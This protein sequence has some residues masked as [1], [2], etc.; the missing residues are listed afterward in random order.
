MNRCYFVNLFCKKISKFSRCRLF[1]DHVA[2]GNINRAESHAHGRP[3]D[4]KRNIFDHKGYSNSRVVIPRSSIADH[5]LDMFNRQC[6][7]TS[8]Q[9]LS[10]HSL[11]AGRQ[12]P[13]P[14]ATG[15]AQV[16]AQLLRPNT[17]VAGREK[18]S[19]QSGSDTVV[20]H[21]HLWGSRPHRIEPMPLVE[22]RFY[23]KN[24]FPAAQII[25]ILPSHTGEIPISP[26][27]VENGGQ[28][29]ARIPFIIAQFIPLICAVFL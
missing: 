11:S 2:K 13:A 29:P 19:R 24:L 25:P 28:I 21:L 8:R 12:L 10:R 16:A 18:T 6:F 9:L 3:E 1:Y 23:R 26:A 7:E 5:L 22:I 27:A 15:A 17:L 14:I 4:R 20:A